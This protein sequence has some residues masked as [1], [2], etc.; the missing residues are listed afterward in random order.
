MYGNRQAL[1][2]AHFRTLAKGKKDGVAAQEVT[3]AAQ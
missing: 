3:S 2:D 1:I